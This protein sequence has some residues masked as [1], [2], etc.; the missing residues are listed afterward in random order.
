ML[1]R[2]WTVGA[3][4]LLCP[5]TA[6][7]QEV[8]SPEPAVTSGD[9]ASAGPADR[10][11]LNVALPTARPGCGQAVTT[12]DIVVCGRRV[13]TT[14]RLDPRVMAATRRAG[15]VASPTAAERLLTSCSAVSARGCPGQGVVPVSG[16]VT[17]LVGTLVAAIRGDDWKEP[18]RP[19]EPDEYQVYRSLAPADD[20]EP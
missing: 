11:T 18:M 2:G 19:T 15:E 4:L 6:T 1:K 7:A 20:P 12:D 8:V 3:A 13:D 16:G 5:A 14:Y 9:R 10:P 17:R